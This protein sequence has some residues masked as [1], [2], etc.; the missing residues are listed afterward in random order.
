M[1][2][3][4]TKPRVIVV[5]GPNGAGKSTSAPYVLRDALEVPE[6]VNADAIAGGL[7]AFS[8]ETYER[9]DNGIPDHVSPY[10]S[11]GTGSG[12][13]GCEVVAR[14][15]YERGLEDKILA[16]FRVARWC[17]LQPG[18]AQCVVARSPH[19]C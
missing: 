16:P 9:D 10:F 7:S 8:P 12:V 11:S 15:G 5:A 6:F 18:A 4:A 2:E 14:C 3:F 13:K 19:C 17:G 1:S